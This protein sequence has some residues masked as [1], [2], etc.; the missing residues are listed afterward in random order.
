MGLHCRWLKT[1]G[2]LKQNKTSWKSKQKLTNWVVK[3][4]E[5][6]FTCGASDTYIATIFS[7]PPSMDNWKRSELVVVEKQEDRAY[8]NNPWTPIFLA[9]VRDN[10]KPLVL[11][12]G[13][14]QWLWFGK[15]SQTLDSV[16]ENMTIQSCPARTNQACLNMDYCDKDWKQIH[17]YAFIVEIKWVSDSFSK[18]L[19]RWS[20]VRRSRHRCQKKELSTLRFEVC[21][22]HLWILIGH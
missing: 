20:F 3:F 19:C 22:T 2:K 6:V 10:T 7:I 14:V 17:T 5:H 21:Q 4:D 12:I 16:W 11:S 13:R 9:Q 18:L 15:C 1:S 8:I